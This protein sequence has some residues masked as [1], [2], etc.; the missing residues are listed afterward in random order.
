MEEELIILENKIKENDSI[1]LKEE[2][3][4]ALDDACDKYEKEKPQA[5]F[6][7]CIRK[8]ELAQS[9]YE[10]KEEDDYKYL[11]S[12]TIIDVAICLLN[13]DKI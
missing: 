12:R 13:Q 1:E 7:M 10:T 11:L 2:L 3:I 8:K 5:F 6:G 9:I 4:K